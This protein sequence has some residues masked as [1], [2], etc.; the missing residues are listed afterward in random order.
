[1]T[2][3]STDLV[4]IQNYPFS[5]FGCSHSLHVDVTQTF[6]FPNL[7]A[8]TPPTF[9]LIFVFLQNFFAGAIT[10]KRFSWVFGIILLDDIKEF[11]KVVLLFS[12]E[13]P[14]TSICLPNALI[15]AY[16]PEKLGSSENP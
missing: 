12:Q 15:P 6:D 8:Q 11:Q 7:F 16:N 5:N 14:T 2:L 10:K 13:G 9:V 1:M 4:S 3:V